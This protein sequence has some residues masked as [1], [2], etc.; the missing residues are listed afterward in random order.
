MA[1]G[2]IATAIAVCAL[3]FLSSCGAPENGVQVR[4]DVG[5]KISDSKYKKLVK[6]IKNQADGAR[7]T[8]HSRTGNTVTVNLAPVA[9]AEAFAKKLSFGTVTHVDG[10]VIFFEP[11]AGSY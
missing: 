10:N 2:L 5:K 6:K 3:V 9:D 11:R 4:V 7:T 8:S 1:K